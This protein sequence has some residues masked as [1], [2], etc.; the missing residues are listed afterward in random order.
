MDMGKYK[1]QNKGFY[2]ILTV[3]EIF[4]RYSFAISVYRKDISNMTKAVTELFGE[5]PELAQ[6]DYGKE[7]YNLGVKTLLEKHNIKYFS[8]KSAIAERFNRALKTALWK[9]FYTKGT[10][11]WIDILDESVYNYNN[12]TKRC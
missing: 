9:Y 3:V 11:R 8:T 6:F 1:N 12:E 10:Y 7:F 4:S 2:W 5:D